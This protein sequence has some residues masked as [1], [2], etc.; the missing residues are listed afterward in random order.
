[1]HSANL[2]AYHCSLL[3]QASVLPSDGPY[4]MLA[5]SKKCF[6]VSCSFPTF[7]PHAYARWI[8]RKAPLFALFK[9]CVI[10][11]RL[12]A[13][14]K[15]E[16]F[17]GRMLLMC[18]WTELR[19]SAELDWNPWESFLVKRTVIMWKIWKLSSLFTCMLDTLNIYLY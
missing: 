10:F 14:W 7:L 17:A 11:R 4:Y 13:F 3:L 19:Q 12:I 6:C 16:C 8:A 9:C 18:F 1:M 5:C 15:V 2:I